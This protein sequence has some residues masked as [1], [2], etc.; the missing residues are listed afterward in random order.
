MKRSYVADD[1]RNMIVGM[2][3]AGLTLSKIRDIVE[4]PKSTISKVFKRYTE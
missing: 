2:R 4:R 1:V 3:E